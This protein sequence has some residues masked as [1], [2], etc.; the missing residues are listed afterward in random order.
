MIHRFVLSLLLALV[1]TTVAQAD[2]T[3]GETMIAADHPDIRYLGR[4]GGLGDAMVTVNSGSGAVLRFTGRH[5]AATFDQ[6]TVTHP[7]QIYARIDRGAPV[8]Y[9]VDRNLIDLTA[10]P[11]SRGGFHTLEITVK[12]VDE[13]ANR[14]NPPLRS[15]LL[16][17]GF[18]LDPGTATLP[19]PPP[20]NRRIEFLGDSIT[21]GRARHRPG[22]RRDRLRR[23]EGLRVADR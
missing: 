11:L 20:E 3:T 9:T 16:L 23:H 14:W 8:L 15:G 10:R 21:Q 4:W 6:S 1:A 22:D 5:I 17:T 19:P 7:P 18:R 13:R 12:D 2:A